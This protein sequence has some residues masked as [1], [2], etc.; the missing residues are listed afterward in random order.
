MRKIAMRIT[1][2]VLA[3]MAMGPSIQAQD[4][5]PPES[6]VGTRLRDFGGFVQLDARFGDMM[7]EFAAF[8]GARAAV[9]L[10]RRVY[11]GLGGA[12][13]ATDNA[14]VPGPTPGT[15]HPI[16]MGYGGL[17][18]GYVIP[19]NSFVEIT[20]DVL[21]GAGGVKLRD[22]D[23]D[24]AIFVFEP[25]VGIELNL[26]RVARLGF[27]AGYR[28]VGDTDLPGVEDSDLRGFTGTAAIK[29]GWF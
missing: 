13:L 19:T 17:L 12:G 2:G 6:A 10:K 14:V 21:V 23:T 11:I 27:G 25:S 18:I 3:L 20:T 4:R 28:F 22:V 15:T 26:S 5:E 24:D 7:G 29:V 9:L 16:R 1:M 8:A